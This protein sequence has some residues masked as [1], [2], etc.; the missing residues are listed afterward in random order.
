MSADPQWSANHRLRTAALSTALDSAQKHKEH[1]YM[2][3]EADRPMVS[4]RSCTLLCLCVSSN[5]L[6]CISSFPIAILGTTWQSSLN[7][8]VIAVC[9]TATFLHVHLSDANKGYLH[10]YLLNKH[11]QDNWTMHSYKILLLGNCQ[12]DKQFMKSV[13]Q[14]ICI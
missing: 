2:T 11:H 5:I 13:S 8:E 1:S 9:R 4:W 14:T 6:S 7:S 10:T 3:I 12:T